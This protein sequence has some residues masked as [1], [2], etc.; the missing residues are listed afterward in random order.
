VIGQIIS[1]YRLIERLDAGAMGQVYKAEDVDGDGTV[2]VKVVRPAFDD[3]HSARRRF[4]R[5]AQAVSK[6]DHPNVVTLHEVVQKGDLNFLIMEFVDGASL[7]SQMSRPIVLEDVLRI[8]SEITAGVA[9][10]HQVGIMH[11]DIKPENIM[12][13]RSGRCRVLDF[14]V[15]RLADRSSSTK[16][17]RL[18]GT[19]PYM[20]PEQ[21]QGEKVDIRIDVYALGALMF[22]M[23]TGSL[24]F[25]G[26]DESVLYYQILNVEPPQLVSA[27]VPAAVEAIVHKAMAKRPKDRYKT[28]SD[29]LEELLRVRFDV[30][31]PSDNAPASRA[32][33]R[34]GFRKWFGMG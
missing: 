19:L 29:M 8:A 20:A 12:L 27:S 34:K 24:P 15:A 4:L 13:D 22:E 25:E 14:G 16:R 3:R 2:A 7:R 23:L 21:I 11:R 6:I 1:H 9:A 26:N 33:A 17:R 5:E 31:P 30:D 10:A 28:A 32:G 18:I